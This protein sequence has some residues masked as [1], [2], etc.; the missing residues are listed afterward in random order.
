M[1][2]IE[3]TL[4]EGRGPQQIRSLIHELHEAVVR[5]IAA[6]PD[7]V[8]VAVREVPPTRRAAGDVTIEERRTSRGLT[9]EKRGTG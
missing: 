8:R 3:V 9:G 5:A 7:S 2:L 6:P 4:V 1:P